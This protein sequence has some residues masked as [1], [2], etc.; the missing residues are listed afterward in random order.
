VKIVHLN[1]RYAEGG[2]ATVMQTLAA[3]QRAAGH[4]VKILYGYSHRGFDSPQA[5]GDT[6]AIRLGS[7]PRVMM[8]FWEH[9]LGIYGGHLGPR[10]SGVL[11][12]WCAWADVVH[13]H[14]I[15]SYMGGDLELLK[16]I[17]AK[18]KA[19][20]WTI[21]DSWAITG[22]CAI[23]GDCDGWLAGCAPCKS[24][25][26]YP[27]T[28]LDNAGE[29]R[30]EKLALITG[31]AAKLVMVPLLPWM[32]ARLAQVF[33]TV[34]Q[35]L[36]VNGAKVP[37]LA[38][39]DRPG[40]ERRQFLI[41]AAD[42]SDELKVP[43]GCIR[44]ILE[45]TE[46]SI[47]TIG[48]NPPVAHARVTNHGFLP[49]D[50]KFARVLSSA[51]CYA[52]FSTIDMCPMSVIEALIAGLPVVALSSTSTDDL[53]RMVGGRTVAN[54]EEMIAV[55]RQE[56]WWRLYEPQDSFAL[57]ARAAGLFSVD[58]MCRKYSDAYADATA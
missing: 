56:S 8:N 50:E 11:A 32:Q 5:K 41:S 12:D 55:V 47:V 20:V 54:L 40:R 48:K 14:A 15:H 34:R 37:G 6:H 27:K 13:V 7:F 43:R 31:A 4:E 58:T 25:Q 52:F 17:F 49:R 36:I 51:S 35:K 53:L 29:F 10:N 42:L 45:R 39:A 1:V 9:K 19:V 44:S 16:I 2:S 57:A 28:L 38:P 46:I 26:Q 22:R 3:S 30:R 21:H 23:I 33:P 18:S 24:L